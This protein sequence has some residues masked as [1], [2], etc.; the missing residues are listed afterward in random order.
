MNC[1]EFKDQFE[2]GLSLDE[3]AKNHLESCGN[4]KKFHSEGLQL[5]QM[6]RT[7]PKVEAPKDFEFGFRSKLAQSK[8]NKPLSPIWQTLRYALPLTAAVLIFGFVFINS[9][10]FSNDQS[11]QTAES[12]Q[13]D[14]K[15]TPAENFIE[16]K[17]EPEDKLIADKTDEIDKTEVDDK[18]KITKQVEIRKEGQILPELAGSKQKVIVE[19]EADKEKILSIDNKPE[20][21]TEKILNVDSTLNVTKTINPPGTDSTES[22]ENKQVQQEAKTFTAKDILTQLGINTSD[23]NG[24]LMVNSVT[25]SSSGESSGVKVGDIVTAIDGQDVSGRTL[26]VR[27]IQ[28]KILR[29]KRD[30]QILNITIKN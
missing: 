21:T 27:S 22:I 2:D 18:V 3:T 16:T 9:N 6:I 25:K 30:G 20:D 24:Q 17:T 7:L 12:Q 23:E 13:I 1:K 19:K 29:I 14:Q 5:S 11:K 15:L 10:L 28:G 8:L 26:S 4:C